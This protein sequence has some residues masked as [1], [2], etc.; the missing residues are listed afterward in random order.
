MAD[1][2]RE[3]RV[4]PDWTPEQVAENHAK[5]SNNVLPVLIH[6]AGGSVTVTRE[7]FA[8]MRELYGGGLSLY[9]EQVGDGEA[10]RVTLV[11]KPSTQG[12]PV[13]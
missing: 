4:F 11:R 8:L 1:E 7:E 3:R 2:R 6:R 9:M 13:V 12:G 10:V 5:I